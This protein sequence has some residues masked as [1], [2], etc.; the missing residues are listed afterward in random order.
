LTHYCF[1]KTVFILQACRHSQFRGTRKS[2]C[3]IASVNFLS[4]CQRRS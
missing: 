1:H 2:T 4:L 3:R